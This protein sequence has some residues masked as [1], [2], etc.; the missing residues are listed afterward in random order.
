MSSAEFPGAL[1]NLLPSTVIVSVIGPESTGKTTLARA[2]AKSLSGA[3]LPEYARQYLQDPT[4][5]ESDLEFIT[6]EQLS[7]ET[8]FVRAGPAVGILDTDGIVLLVWWLERFG[9]VPD[10]L[11]SHLE[12]QYPRRYL[13]TAPDLEWKF[14]PLRESESDRER[15]FSV[16]ID[17]MTRRGH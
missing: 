15:L 1:S 9:R 17:V 10:F 16:Y 4:Y 14:D 11:E 5:D 12:I 2:L 13:L 3:W 8:A 6:R 7:R